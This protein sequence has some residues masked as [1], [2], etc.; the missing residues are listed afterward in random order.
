MNRGILII[1]I[2]S[3]FV[4]LG[5]VYAFGIFFALISGRRQ[6]RAGG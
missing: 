4:A 6:R 1:G 5:N 2:V 3:V